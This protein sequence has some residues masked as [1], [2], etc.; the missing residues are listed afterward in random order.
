MTSVQRGEARANVRVGVHRYARVESNI[1]GSTPAITR[2]RDEIKPEKVISTYQTYLQV[3]VL[4]G[5]GG[6]GG[7]VIIFTDCVSISL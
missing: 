2:W 7:I 4:R 1:K 3:F 6:D 5:G